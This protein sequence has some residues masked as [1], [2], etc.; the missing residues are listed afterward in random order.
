MVELRRASLLDAVAVLA[1]LVAATLL[2]LRTGL[3]PRD[4]AAPVAVVFVPW[5]SPL[6]VLLRA[7]AAGGRVLD[8]GAL[9]SIVVVSPSGPGYADRVLAE[10]ALF[11]LDPRV[12]AWCA[13]AIPPPQ[14][15][16]L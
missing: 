11:V 13:P 10:G 6:D 15:S 9:S 1:F 7:V 14:S 8:T 16:S 2:A 5:T 12:L 3:R 4:P